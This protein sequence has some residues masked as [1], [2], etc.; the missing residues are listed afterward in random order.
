MISTP[1]WILFGW[2]N[3]NKVGGTCSMY[4]RGQ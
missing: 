3:Q 2:W 4:G 1:L